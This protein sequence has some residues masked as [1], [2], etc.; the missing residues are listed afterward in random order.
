[1]WASVKYEIGRLFE[2]FLDSMRALVDSRITAD[3][4][5]G[6][7]WIA[8]ISLVVVVVLWVLRGLDRRRPMR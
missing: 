4:L 8:M 6:L 7:M 2:S 5:R 1:M 3:D